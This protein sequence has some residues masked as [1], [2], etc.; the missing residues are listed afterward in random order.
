MN[1]FDHITQE[2]NKPDRLS[3]NELN[4]TLETMNIGAFNS[5]EALRSWYRREKQKLGESHAIPLHTP[6]SFDSPITLELKRTLVLADIHCPFHDENMLELV[7]KVAQHHAVEQI[8]VAGDVFHFDDISRHS[9]AQNNTRLQ[10][11]LYTGG[12]VL[13]NLAELAPV[14][15]TSGNHDERMATKLDTALSFHNVVTMALNGNTPRNVITVTDYDYVFMNSMFM[16]GHLSSYSAVPG[17]VAAELAQRHKRHVLGGHDHIRGVKMS[18]NGLYFG[19]SIG[20]TMRADHFWYAE[21]RMSK[22]PASQQGFAFIFPDETIVSYDEKG[23]GI[24]YR[25]VKI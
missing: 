3:W 13:L 6:R 9:R 1:L 15:V 16:I 7:R 11:D 19:V 12:K 22:Y 20:G 5:G 14:Y 23:K 21:R 8:V 18:A 17:K 10:T 2:I 24:A 4:N 25:I